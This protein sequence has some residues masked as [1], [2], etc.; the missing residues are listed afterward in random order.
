M[1]PDIYSRSTLPMLERVVRFTQERHG[2]LA[3][4]VANINTPGYKS[5]DLS[6]QKFQESLKQALAG[7]RAAASP[8]EAA[9]LRSGP[10][11]YTPG[12]G[13]AVRGASGVSN[14][15]LRGV[16]ESMKSLLYH[17]ESD[18]SLEKQITEISKNQGLHNM[19]IALMTS[20]LQ[21]LRMAVSENV[22]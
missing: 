13:D 20:Q 11:L 9:V 16:D 6:P 21:Q 8:G 14:D 1:F 15:D 7:Q 17:D 5:R 4:N 3:G 22:T 19:A 10:G 18:V 12:V 2:V